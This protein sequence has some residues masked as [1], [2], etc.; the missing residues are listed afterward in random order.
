MAFLKEH[1]LYTLKH[2]ELPASFVIKETS[3]MVEISEQ[4][5]KHSY[6]TLIWSRNSAGKHIIDCNEYIFV[7]NSM[8][9]I[10]PGQVH[11]IVSNP[12]P[13]GLLILFT[14]GFLS[15]NDSRGNFLQKF[16]MFAHKPYTEPFP[17]QP[18][19]TQL[20]QHY[21]NEMMTAFHSNDKWKYEIIEANLK[22]FLI[23]CN[24]QYLL[25]YKPDNDAKTDPA[26]KLA[27]AFKTMVENHYHEWHQVHDYAEQ[28]NITP[29]YLGEVVK[30]SFHISPKEYINQQLIAEAKRMIAYS[31]E[32]LKKIGYKLGF[33]D[34]NRFCRFFKDTAGI[35]FQDFRNSLR[36]R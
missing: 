29:S 28:L 20:M 19:S 23:E 14:P 31:G 4:P 32:S 25:N 33:E 13:E 18:D 8:F 35:S 30:Q 6:Y 1:P 7:P 24:K 27:V 5:H 26:H 17:L 34:P 2:E 10:H 11:Q 21:A 22:L 9:V 3:K 12:R 15:V 36:H 16:E